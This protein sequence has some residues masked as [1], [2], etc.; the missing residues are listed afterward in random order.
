MKK[1]TTVCLLLTLIGHLSFGSGYQVLLQGN[2]ITGMGNL[3]VMMYSDASSL[4]FNPGA[5]GFMDHNSVQIGF[6]PIFASNTYWNSETEN[7]SYTSNSDNPMGTPFHAF[8]V[9]GP[10]ESKFKFGIGAMTPFGSGVNWGNTWAGRDLLNELTLRAIQIQPTVAYK[11][12]DKLAIGAGL[13]VTIGSVNLMRTVLLDARDEGSDYSEGSVTLDGKA[14][15]AFGY[16]IG[17]FYTP[18]DKIDIGISYRSEVEMKLEDG[19]V[20]FKVPSSVAAFFPEGNT[21]DSSLPL[22]SVLTA[23]LTYHL[24]ENLEIGTQF[25]WVGWGA[26][27]SLDFDFE[28]NTPRLEDTSSPRNYKDSW[29]I[30]L[31]GEYRLENNLQL[32][33]GFY[34][35]KTPV[36]DGYMT[37]ETPDNDRIGLT[38]GLGYSISDKFQIDLSFLYIHSSQREQ[39]TEQA[40]ASGTY[41]LPSA[42]EAGSRNVL[43]GTYRL[44]ALIPGISIAYKF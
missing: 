1:L 32:R 25:D 19:S 18:S 5:M 3:G 44:N 24:S 39:T 27:E 30:H 7:S 2:R 36:Q 20:D 9:W 33:A 26:Y 21:F 6:N 8:A 35:D 31:G 40:I 17:I 16:N 15:T 38:A 43:P 13:D 11:I 23:G 29:V 22:P 12:S 14:T 34:F 10:G 42:T 4:F 37:P 41:T 28:N